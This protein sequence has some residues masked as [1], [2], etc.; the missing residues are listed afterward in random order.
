M[1]FTGGSSIR[2]YV[3]TTAGVARLR[4]QVSGIGDGIPSVI[5][6]AGLRLLDT[7]APLAS[8][9]GG[10]TFE[11]GPVV[12]DVGYRH[13]RVFSSSWIDALALGGDTL[14]TNEVRVGFGVRF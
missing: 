4:P 14:H 11:S 8:V 3:E 10:V 6:N 9:G 13:R 5:A 7:T 1:R 2:P 12:F